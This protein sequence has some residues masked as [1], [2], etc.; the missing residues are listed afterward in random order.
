MVV[1]LDASAPAAIVAALALRAVVL[2]SRDEDGFDVHLVAG[3]WVQ[4]LCRTTD[5]LARIEQEPGDEPEVEFTDGDR[6][7]LEAVVAR[8][9]ES[10]PPSAH[11]GQRETLDTPMRHVKDHHPEVYAKL[12][13]LWSVPRNYAQALHT[14]L[15]DRHAGLLHSDTRALALEVID[16]GELTATMPKPMLRDRVYAYFKSKDPTFVTRS[17]VEGVGF[18]VMSV[19][20]TRR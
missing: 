20:A 13:R 7:V 18:E 8:L 6:E 11:G 3:P 17:A 9:V 5:S 4:L 19:L 16:V 1:P 14:E 12:P 10:T 2:G 15:K